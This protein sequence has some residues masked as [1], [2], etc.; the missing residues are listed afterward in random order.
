MRADFVLGIG[1]LLDIKLSIGIVLGIK[2]GNQHFIWH[3][4]RQL[5]FVPGKL[6]AYQTRLIAKRKTH[7]HTTY[8]THTPHTMKK[9]KTI[10][11]ASI[12]NI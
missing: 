8:D 7:K 12:F 5:A 3:K 9:M 6:L 11:N 2:L 4:T 10:D 1:I